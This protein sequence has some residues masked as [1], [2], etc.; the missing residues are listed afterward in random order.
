MLM[1]STTNMRTI[2]LS[3]QAPDVQRLMAEDTEGPTNVTKAKPFRFGA[4]IDVAASIVDS[5][6]Q[7]VAGGEIYRVAIRSP[8]AIGMGINFAKYQLP[9]GAKMFVYS[10]DGTTVRGSFTSENHKHYGGFAVM[11]VA[12]DTIV[13]EV[14]TPKGAAKP[15]VEISSVVHHYRNT[16]FRSTNPAP[17]NLTGCFGC[18]AGCNVNSACPL[19]DGWGTQIDGV[20]AILTSAGSVLCSGAL[21]NNAA[22]DG[23]QLYLTADHCGGTRAEDW[24]FI[25]NYQTDTCV[26]DTEPSDAQSVQGTKLISRASRSDFLLLELTE[27]IPDSYGAVLQGF[28]AR[29]ALHFD[30]PYSISHPSGDVKKLAIYDGKASVDGYFTEGITH[31]LIEEWDQGV[32]EGGSSGSPIFDKDGRIR[33]QLH[34]GYASC[35]YLFTDFYGR[36]SQSWDHYPDSGEQLE[37]HLGPARVVDSAKLSDVRGRAALKTLSAGTNCPF[38]EK[39]CSVAANKTECCKRGESCIAGVGCTCAE[40][41]VACMAAKEP[42]VV[43]HQARDGARRSGGCGNKAI[44]PSGRTVERKMTIGGHERTYLLHLPAGYNTLTPYPVVTS[45][46]GW[47]EDAADDERDSG[48]SPHADEKGFIVAYLNGY[49]DNANDQPLY[50]QTWQTWQAAGSTSS[51]ESAPICA[52]N[53][54]RS[55]YCYE[56]CAERTAGC[57]SRGCDWTTCV[58]SFDFTGAVFDALEDEFC[59]DV[60]REYVSGF[61][62]GAG[63]AYDL[64]IKFPQRIAAITPTAGAFM[65]GFSE[66]P[67]MPI[68][69]MDIHGNNDDIIPGNA[70]TTVN[71]VPTSESEGGWYYT[72]TTL[73]LENG[74]A[75]GWRQANKCK[76]PNSEYAT[77]ISD[78]GLYCV[79]QGACEATT[80]RC[81]WDGAH[82]YAFNGGSKT[83]KLIS[84]FLLQHSKPTH[85]GKGKSSVAYNITSSAKPAQASA[86]RVLHSAKASYTYPIKASA[87]RPHYGNPA[88][89]C[90]MDEEAKTLDN[91]NFT[92]S[93]CAPKIETNREGEP[94]CV[95]DDLT[96][97]SQ[98]G[99]PA[100]THTD[101]ENMLVFPSCL[102]K[103]NR[104]KKV[105]TAKD[106]RCYLTCTHVKSQS[107]YDHDADVMCP[108]GAVCMTGMRRN[109]HQGVCVFPDQQ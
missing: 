8:N 30:T 17:T 54:G 95:L 89:G 94:Q 75:I 96:A 59:V 24:I 52:L 78:N 90:R 74:K 37:D 47:L 83:G 105:E 79:N 21:I 4:V 98:N 71:Y 10:A 23:R 97:N 2:D 73:M 72:P 62:N 11:P 46:H 87:H 99:C 15:V 19:G 12:G 1:R 65:T 29:D 76:G 35:N 109:P 43:K 40:G 101:A 25:F 82:S 106:F 41:D 91:G 20:T 6:A 42:K 33:G 61:S 69:M 102:G 14:F 49:G 50:G 80:V 85:L 103:S 67:A 63:M 57:D 9:A 31:W 39:K 3:A 32:T 64:A 81:F 93:I 16:F 27:T 44:V 5:T 92:G 60:T 88:K 18:S 38:G 7:Q 13:V 100:S 86:K 34:G 45:H 51:S 107:V 26:S 55:Q 36:L 70:T 56:S 68:P 104:A 22:E 28:D 66:P 48:L 58:D 77:G 53:R 108:T 84:D